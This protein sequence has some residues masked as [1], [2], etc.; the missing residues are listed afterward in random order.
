M[1]IH[2]FGLTID[3]AEI[4]EN[5]SSLSLPLSI[6][7]GA[8]TPLTLRGCHQVCYPK[9]MCK[10]DLASHWQ[11]ITFDLTANYNAKPYMTYTNDMMIPAYRTSSQ[12]AA[13]DFGKPGFAENF[14]TTIGV[15]NLFQQNYIGGVYGPASVSGDQKSNCSLQRLA[16]SSAPSQQNSKPHSFPEFVLGQSPTCRPTSLQVRPAGV[17]PTF[18]QP[19]LASE[20]S[21]KTLGKK[22]WF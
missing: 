18:E 14:K 19:P 7:Q 12:T 8:G 13:Y 21:H 22:R 6:S 15:T 4:Q 11:Q 9:F 2:A 10:V 1:A 5:V 20:Q 17:R 3:Q 16:S